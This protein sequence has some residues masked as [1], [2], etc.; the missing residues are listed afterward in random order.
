MWIL[1]LLFAS[2]LCADHGVDVSTLHPDCK[3]L[4]SHGQSFFIPRCYQ[5][6]GKVDPNCA[7][8]LDNGHAA[9]LKIGLYMFPCFSCGN[10]AK[11]VEDTIK[12]VG[13]R[14]VDI[15]WVD[16]EKL[17]WSSDKNKNREFIQ[18]MVNEIKSK[19]KKA[20]IYSNY[21]M[22]QDIVGLDW[23]AMSDHPLWY[24]H[25]DKLEACSDF[26]PFG[27][28]KKPMFKQYQGTTTLCNGGVDISIS[29]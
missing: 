21:Y 24:A 23:S 26:K 16:V 25:Y 8:N 18:A 14:P 20:G 2:C 6:N 19:G 7:K 10:P 1:L 15:Y 11:Q 3:C 27:G 17:G 9:G 22:W 4:K 12:D 5:S 28:W 29:C 13:S